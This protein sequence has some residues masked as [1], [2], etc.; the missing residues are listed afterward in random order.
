LIY[1]TLASVTGYVFFAYL[2]RSI[3]NQVEDFFSFFYLPWW[4]FGIGLLAIYFINIIFGILPVFNLLRKS[5]A[6]ILSK[7]DI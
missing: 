2:F 5:P 4:L 3:E 6:K 1:T 7:Y